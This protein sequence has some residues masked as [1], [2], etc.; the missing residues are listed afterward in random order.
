MTQRYEGEYIYWSFY[1]LTDGQPYVR[2]A[3]K[4][5]AASLTLEELNEVITELQRVAVDLALLK[6]EDKQ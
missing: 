2:I 3:P 1:K 5:N 6:M 4:P